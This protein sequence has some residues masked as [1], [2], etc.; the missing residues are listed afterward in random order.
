[1]VI[2]TLDGRCSRSGAD[3]TNAKKPGTNEPT[4][5]THTHH[6]L[7]QLSSTW[8]NS[9]SL[10]CFSV[11]HTTRV[12]FF[13]HPGDEKGETAKR[14]GGGRNQKKKK[15][16]GGRK[17]WGEGGKG[18]KHTH[19]I[20]HTHTHTKKTQQTHT[21]TQVLFA[22]LFTHFCTFITTPMPTSTHTHHHHSPLPRRPLPDEVLVA[23]LGIVG[24]FLVFSLLLLLSWAFFFFFGRVACL[25][26]R[27]RGAK[28]GGGGFVF[29]FTITYYHHFLDKAK[30]GQ[31]RGRGEIFSVANKTT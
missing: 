3:W 29:V 8:K 28:G 27:F 5:F 21:H 4:N 14:G 1:M 12:G 2:G 11:Q 15:M 17:K 30:V 20:I 18:P 6:H 31:A 13:F 26:E 10:F 9:S 23:I 16:Q 24:L 7:L 25:M 22:L 19:I